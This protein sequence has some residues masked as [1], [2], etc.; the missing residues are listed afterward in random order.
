MSE[1][2]FSSNVFGMHCANCVTSLEKAIA[3]VPGVQKVSVNLHAKKVVVYGKFSITS[4]KEVI[5]NKGY[6]FEKSM[7]DRAKELWI[8]WMLAVLSFFVKDQLGILVFIGCALAG[9]LAKK[10]THDGLSSLRQKDYKMETLI[11]IGVWGAAL[12]HIF[13]LL[14]GHHGMGKEGVILLAIYLT[15]Q[16]LE[17]RLKDKADIAIKDLLNLLPDDVVLIKNNKNI[18]T[19]LKD[20]KIGDCIL[21]LPGQSVPL[22]GV[23]I[24]GSSELNESLITG[25]SDPVLKVVDDG[26]IGGTLNIS[27]RIVI[28]VSASG[29]EGYLSK[30]VEMVENASAANIPVQG[31][32]DKIVAVFVPIVLWAAGLA[33][34]FWLMLPERMMEINQFLISKLAIDMEPLSWFMVILAVLVVSCPCPLGIA[35]P[36]ALFIG[37][38]RGAKIGLIIRDG[39]G[40]ED[41]KSCKVLILDKTGTLTTGNPTVQSIFPFDGFTEEQVLQHAASAEEGS[42]HPIAKAILKNCKSRKITW[43]KLENYKYHFG[44]GVEGLDENGNKVMAGTI[45]WALSEPVVVSDEIPTDAT[46][47]A[48]SIDN[49]PIG[50]IAL[51]DEIRK[52]AFETI[53][54]IQKMNIKIVIASGDRKESVKAVAEKLSIKKYFYAQKP[55]DKLALVNEYQKDNTHVVFAGDGVN[56]APALAAATV[57]IAMGDGSDLAKQ[58]GGLILPKGNLLNIYKAIVLSQKTFSIV[59]QNLFWAAIYNVV[60]IPLAFFG[61]LHPIVAQSAMVISDLI[62]I[63][64]SLR[65]QKIKI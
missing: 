36:L 15:G 14:I 41:L 65:L 38:G 30:L 27:G 40:L 19:K 12:H 7:Q 22:D 45:A 48:V 31:L 3:Q 53:R 49:K 21:V 32:V 46:I 55:E 47:V 20:V 52:N 28:K 42:E 10:L 63:L 39:K 11:F 50:L 43:Q 35:T 24:E 9:D 56:D 5:V 26:V 8:I 17:S 29:G 54:K 59:G 13:S 61:V 44:S 57:G 18:T 4:V 60:A 37:A 23:V 64:N 2:G 25:E 16:H 62:V 51:N 6:S 58:N 33:G 1:P 34:V